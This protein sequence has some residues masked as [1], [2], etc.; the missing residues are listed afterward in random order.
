MGMFDGKTIVVT[1][2]TGNLGVAVSRHL[3]DEGAT[4]I[5]MARNKVA[6]AEL[7]KQLGASHTAI[8]VDLAD[9]DATMATGSTLPPVDAIAALAGGFAMGKTVLQTNAN[10]W[11]AMRDINVQ[12]MLNVIAAFV[13]KM[14]ERRAGKI[15]TVGAAAAQS[16]KAK[17]GPYIAAKSE[18]MRITET[19][20]AEL[21]PYGINVNSVLPTVID[22]PQNRTAM[23][24]A[25]PSHWVA[26][27]SLA[28]FI[29]FLMSPQAEAIN[30][31]LIPVAGRT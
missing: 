12:T 26:P 28:A 4:L 22:T 30:G 16:G 15:V 31:A 9:P 24:K 14:I 23:P 7:A 5:L 3:A 21:G 1:G 11:Q 25:D 17:M 10:D 18:V 20:A 19:L 6:V 2:A 8:T 29:A 13:P 27:Q